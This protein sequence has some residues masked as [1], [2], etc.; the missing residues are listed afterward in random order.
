MHKLMP[1]GLQRMWT[2]CLLLLFQMASTTSDS[3]RLEFSHPSSS[4][5]D[6]VSFYANFHLELQIGVRNR[7]DLNE[8]PP[9]YEGKVGKAYCMLTPATLLAT[10]I[11]TS[12]SIVFSHWLH[13]L[14]ELSS[15]ESLGGWHK[16]W[17]LFVTLQKFRLVSLTL[18]RDS[19]WCRAVQSGGLWCHWYHPSEGWAEQH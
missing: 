12:K 16:K 11:G 19:S 1:V 13:S 8:T 3:F 9:S 7:A 2:R 10:S 14:S 5:Q 15:A 17:D 4:W 6:Q 18:I